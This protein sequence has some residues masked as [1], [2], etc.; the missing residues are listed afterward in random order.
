MFVTMCRFDQ[1]NTVLSPYHELLNEDLILPQLAKT[2]YTHTH[3]HNS[4]LWCTGLTGIA[5]S[6]T[7]DSLDYIQSDYNKKM[8]LLSQHIN[9]FAMECQQNHTVHTCTIK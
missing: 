2:L 4:Q 1:S 7:Q 8:P 6:N 5:L 9:G 3:A